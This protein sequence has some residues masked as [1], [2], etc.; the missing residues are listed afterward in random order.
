M[1]EVPT[2]AAPKEEKKVEQV[3]EVDEKK[4]AANAKKKAAQKAKKEALA[5]AQKEEVKAEELTPE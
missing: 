5:A 4:K 1:L 2:E 3:V